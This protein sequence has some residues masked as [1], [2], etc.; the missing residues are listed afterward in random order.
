MNCSLLQRVHGDGRAHKSARYSIWCV[1]VRCSVL[2]CVAVCCS[3]LQCVAVRPWRQTF[4]QVSALLNMVCCRLLQYVSVSL[5]G[6]TFAKV[7]VIAH[8]YLQHKMKKKKR[9][10]CKCVR[11]VK[12][13]QKSLHTS[14]Y[15][16]E[17]KKE[18]VKECV[19]VC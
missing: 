16:I 12:H 19:A 9:V 4:A 2:Q 18:K 7:I 11:R 6:Q 14:I 8:I 13:S 1:A 3:V 5:W 15:Y 17:W 10:H